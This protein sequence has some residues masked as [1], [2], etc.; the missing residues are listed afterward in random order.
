MLITLDIAW[1]GVY[2]RVNS[3]TRIGIGRRV[4][5]VGALLLTMKLEDRVCAST[6]TWVGETIE[7]GEWSSIDT[8]LDWEARSIR[9]Q[10]LRIKLQRSE[11]SHGSSADAS[12]GCFR[13]FP[14]ELPVEDHLE[15]TNNWSNKV[16]RSCWSHPYLLATGRQNSKHHRCQNMFLEENNQDKWRC[17]MELLDGGSTSSKETALS[18][19]I[20]WESGSDNKWSWKIKLDA[21]IQ[22]W[23]WYQ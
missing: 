11:E 8:W 2:V 6:E 21:M 7:A 14:M 12:V 15:G 18:L 19:V 9:E 23:S 13:Y 1:R 3:L 17:D 22:Y 5:N 10:I 4:V 16:Y 20:G